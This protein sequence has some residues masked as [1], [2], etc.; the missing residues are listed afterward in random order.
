[1]QK[2]GATPED[3]V[4]GWDVDDTS[5]KWKEAFY[6]SKEKTEDFMSRLE[7]QLSTFEKSVLRLYLEGWSG[8]EIAQKL[9]RPARS[10]DNAIQRIRAK[11]AK[12]AAK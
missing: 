2:M 12:I 1:M 3:I 11:A 7:A 6:L 5:Q 9:S 10:A 4:G 8:R